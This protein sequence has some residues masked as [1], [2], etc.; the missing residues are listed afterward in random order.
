MIRWRQADGDGARRRHSSAFVARDAMVGLRICDHCRARRPFGRSIGVTAG[1]RE[2]AGGGQSSF[3]A[4]YGSGSVRPAEVDLGN[5]WWLGSRPGWRGAT[6]IVEPMAPQIAMDR[7]QIAGFCR[8]WQVIEFYVFGSAVRVPPRA[9]PI[10][11]DWKRKAELLFFIES[12]RV[13]SSL[14]AT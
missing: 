3:S 4:E 1:N 5:S 12:S 13:P 9:S 7:D 10:S 14:F 11:E 8:K 2:L 6:I